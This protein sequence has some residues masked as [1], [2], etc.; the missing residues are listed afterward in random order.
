MDP[1]EI[2]DFKDTFLKKKIL[3]I[4]SRIFTLQHPAYN[5]IFQQKHH[6]FSLNLVPAKITLNKKGK[7]S[8]FKSS[9]QVHCLKV[10]SQ[11][12]EKLMQHLQS[13]ALRQELTHGLCKAKDLLVVGVCFIPD[14]GVGEVGE[15]WER[16]LELPAHDGH[17][18]VDLHQAK[19]E[20]ILGQQHLQ[21]GLV[22]SCPGA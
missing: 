21:D 6:Y 10:A 18:Q 16:L 4:L 2:L 20:P 3:F 11:S 15:G 13:A 17:H 5:E 22:A 9:A 14:E 8:I 7:T 12:K 1:N 19:R